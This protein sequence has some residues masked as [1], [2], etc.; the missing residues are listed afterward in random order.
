MTL[1][2]CLV[3][4]GANDWLGGVEYIN[5]LVLALASLPPEVRSTYELCL[6]CNNTRDLAAH[7]SIRP[8]LSKI[9]VLE[10]DL[11][12]AHW[13][14]SLLWKLQKKVFKQ[15]NPQINALFQREAI[16]FVYPYFDET[17]AQLKTQPYQF[18]AWIPDFQDKYLPHFFPETDIQK[19]NHLYDVITRSTCPI[20]LSSKT[21]EADFKHFFPNALNKTQ[22]L[23]FK[24]APKPEWY[25][26]EPLHVQQHY[27][28]PDRFFLVSNQFWQ[29][30]NHLTVLKAL[31][32]LQARSIYPVIVCTGY[33]YDYRQP[34]YINSV[35]Q[36]IHTLD[37]AHQVYLL[38]LIPRLDQIQLMRRSLAVV[39]PSLFE[40][41]STVVEDARCL[42]KSMILS[43]IPVH[44][45]QAPPQSLYFDRL[46][47]EALAARLSEVWEN[48]PSGPDREREAIARRHSLQAIE[49][50][51]HQFLAIVKGCLSAEFSP[52]GL[53]GAG[54]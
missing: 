6:L 54:R 38:G 19:R 20:V 18:A 4:Q 35:L 32:I 33:I 47:P 10:T 21:A 44:L 26:P 5:N 3:Q 28:L 34:D 27:C 46:F 52:S 16:N 25:G 53:L 15:A 8:H 49:S 30:K 22:V 51:G 40:G 14:N 9:Y 24:T 2:I 1:K 48:W 39:Q 37:L 7:A 36:T 17:V 45:E 11:T 12:P 50:V 31:K 41:W 29:H 13:L 43:D 23:S 42:G